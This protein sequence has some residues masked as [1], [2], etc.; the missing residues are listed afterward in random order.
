M[1][2]QISLTSAAVEAATQLADAAVTLSY[3]AA[4]C[5]D[6]LDGAYIDVEQSFITTAIYLDV[7]DRD[8]LVLATDRLHD[9]NLFTSFGHRLGWSSGV[10]TI[11]INDTKV[12]IGVRGKV[13]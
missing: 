9:A 3:V 4:I 5:G 7:I 2:A 6:A 1:K 10:A 12:H 13:A 11:E 8:A